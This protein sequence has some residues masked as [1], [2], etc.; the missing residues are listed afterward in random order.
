ML[1]RDARDHCLLLHALSLASLQA[2]QLRRW[3]PG[4]YWI[5]HKIETTGLV[6][7]ISCLMSLNVA[8][9]GKEEKLSECMQGLPFVKLCVDASSIVRALQIA[10][11]EKGLH[12]ATRF[13]QG[14]AQVIRLFTVQ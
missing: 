13:L 9:I 4:H 8:L 1:V 5:G 10:Q 7:L 2:H 3:S 14:E 12:K 11:D 6:G